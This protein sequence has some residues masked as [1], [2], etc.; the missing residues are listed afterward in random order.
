MGFKKILFF[1]L[2]FNVLIFS[3][4]FSSYQTL[5]K[6]ILLN[7]SMVFNSENNKLEIKL[8]EVN[9]N[10]AKF[11]FR[12]NNKI[13]KLLTY[14]LGTNYTILT[15]FEISIL[16]IN[17]TR[18]IVDFE[19]TILKEDDLYLET[20]FWCVGRQ[21]EFKLWELNNFENRNSLKKN[22]ETL[23][24]SYE[25]SLTKAKANGNSTEI[26]IYE[27]KIKN[28]YNE[29]YTIP[30]N[31]NYVIY[32]GPFVGEKSHSGKTNVKG[33]I[34]YVFKEGGA[35]LIKID[36]GIKFNNL[37]KILQLGA[38]GESNGI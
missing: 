27:N 2:F 35:F 19:I 10:Y 21:L 22:Y 26:N 30:N 14:Q 36:G 24:S 33:E 11:Q 5:T 17:T 9:L 4:I 1:L 25:N 15:D 16:D 29:I 37:E 8:M 3:N 13:V 18:K 12:E 32:S 7:N 28:S 38:C 6:E 23:L 31:I 20:K 34:D